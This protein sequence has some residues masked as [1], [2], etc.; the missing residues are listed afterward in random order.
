M[1]AEDNVA[2]ELG[3]EIDVATGGD[4]GN[5]ALVSADH[6]EFASRGS[7]EHCAG[8]DG[9]LVTGSMQLPL[10]QKDFAEKVGQRPT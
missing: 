2:K 1:F 6:G 7:L 9:N 4:L 8:A 5:V 3:R 10:N